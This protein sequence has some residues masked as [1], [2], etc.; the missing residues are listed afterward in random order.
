M[1][2]LTRLKYQKE[3]NR[4]LKQMFAD[5]SLENQAIKELMRKKLG[6]PAAR[7]PAAQDLVSKRWSQRR[8]CASVG[9]SRGSYHPVARVRN[10]EP[11]QEAS[12]A[13]KGRPPVGDSGSCITVCAKIDWSSTI[14][15]P[16]TSTEPWR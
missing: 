4:R 8:A 11:V 10:D 9:L 5:L 13:L 3:E 14:N 7:C 12:R 1:V 15:A 6:S 2:E 16:C